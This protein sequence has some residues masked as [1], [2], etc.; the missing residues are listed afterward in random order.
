M[1]RGKSTR[2]LKATAILGRNAKGRKSKEET[3]ILDMG[4]RLKRK[5]SQVVDAPS[6]E[7]RCKGR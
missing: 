2:L 3:S 5:P 4:K 6:G 7:N 1:G